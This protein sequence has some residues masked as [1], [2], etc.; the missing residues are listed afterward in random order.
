[1]Q[2][3]QPNPPLPPDV[4]A[5]ALS[6]LS[7]AIWLQAETEVT[8]SE[9]SAGPL[10]HVAANLLSTLPN[11]ADALWAKCIQRAGGWPAGCGLPIAD[12]DGKPWADDAARRKAMGYREGEGNAE[13]A[14]RVVGIVRVVFEIYKKSKTLRSPLDPLWRLP[15]AWTWMARM[16]GNP[17]LLEA[18]V[19]PQVLFGTWA[20]KRVLPYGF[21]NSF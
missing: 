7:K 11:F 15:R 17:R 16:V 4:Y 21:L 13:F 10:A 8:A 12:V 19:A 20:V 18:P 1:L 6:S 9:K 2:L 3:L 14:V 5:A